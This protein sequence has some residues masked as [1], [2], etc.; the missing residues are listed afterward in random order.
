MFDLHIHTA[1]TDGMHFR[2]II[3]EAESSGIEAVGLVD[4]AVVTDDPTLLAHKHILA[5]VFDHTY[6]LRRNALEEYSTNTDVR[7]YDGIELDYHSSDRD[8][9]A[10]FL[11]SSSFDYTIGSIHYV[12]GTNIQFSEAFEA[13]SEEELDT[14]VE[15]Y[16][17]Q[18][19]SL[20]RSELFDIAA[21]P[22]LIERNPRTAGR[23]TPQQ[24]D[25]IAVAFTESDTI[26]EF[27]AGDVD[28]GSA[29]NIHPREPLRSR[30]LER[31]VSF[32]YG[33]DTHNPGEISSRTP[34]L[35]Q[36][37]ED[38]DATILPPTDICG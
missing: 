24:A 20:I 2:D 21:H 32:T 35:R 25:R 19:E 27:N 28:S 3:A 7:L 18:L 1:Y 31:D 16:Y 23:T 9:I 15:A 13:H 29:V 36:V 5:H 14:V 6:Q 33:S 26:P 8:L 37:A 30:L 17:T 4:H 12:C 38:C 10:E 34:V 11:Q 22:D